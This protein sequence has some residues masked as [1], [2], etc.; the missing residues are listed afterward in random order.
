MRIRRVTVLGLALSI[1]AAAS[2]TVGAQA[3]KPK[4]LSKQEQNDVNTLVK[5]VDGISMGQP[6][7]AD[8]GIKLEQSHYLK[9]QDGKTFMPFTLTVE[10]SKLTTPGVAMY[11]RVVPKEAAAAP[12][13]KKDP[14]MRVEFPWDDLQFFDVPADG[15]LSR[16]LAVPGGEYTLYVAFKEK[17]TGKRNEV[18]KTSVF[19]QDLSVPDYNKPELVLSSVI[20]ADTVEASEALDPDKQ[21]ENPYTFGTMRLVPSQTGQFKKTSELQ[22]V[23]WVYGVTPGTAQKP[24][25]TIDY[26]FHQKLAEGEKYFNKTA[27]Q[28]LNAQTLP[29]EFDLS[30]GHLLM[31]TL[32]VPLASFPPGDYRLEIKVSDKPSGKSVTHNVNFVVAA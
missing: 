2:L 32:S 6:A 23:F 18:N 12:A 20:L 26:S 21:R 9:A 3:P 16:A 19:R 31:G 4:K 24:D 17:S 28:P 8:F 5:I 29:P 11:V 10:R 7:P 25:V 1:I 14:K 22:L 13:D 15:R 30:V 27:P